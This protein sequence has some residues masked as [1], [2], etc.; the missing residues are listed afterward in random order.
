[1]VRLYYVDC[2]ETSVS[3][4]SDRRRVLEQ[5]RYFGLAEPAKLVAAGKEAA[6]FVRKLLADKKF[7]LPLN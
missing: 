7:T 1:M 5:S 3:S 2:P 4:R 6:S